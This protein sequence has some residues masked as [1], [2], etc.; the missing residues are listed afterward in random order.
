MSIVSDLRAKHCRPFQPGTPPLTPVEVNRL[1]DALGNWKTSG[2]EI[3]RL[4][5][6]KN[7][8]ETMAFV[9]AVA[10]ISH[11]QDHHPDLE[12]G[13]NK[14]LIRYSSHEVGG[15]SENDFICAANVDA[16]IAD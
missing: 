10:F 14:C 1:L 3:S 13:Y 11:R 5:N 8:Y 12:V 16:L 15:L 4:F 6:F 2:K 7:Y 9:N